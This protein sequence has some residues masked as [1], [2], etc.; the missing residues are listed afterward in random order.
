MKMQDTMEKIIELS[1]A[2]ECIVISE[3]SSNA[4]VRWANN[5]TTTNG[6]AEAR[7][8]YV[9][10]IKN[11]RVGVVGRTYFPD[12]QLEDLVR[13]SE[14]ACE[15]KPEAEDYAPLIEGISNDGWGESLDRIGIEVFSNFAPELAQVFKEAGSS[16]IKLF[17]FAD[18]STSAVYLATSSGMRLGHMQGEGKLELNAKS[19]DYSRSSWVGQA[20]ST[21]KDID[22][23][24]HYERLQQRLGWA[25]K[26]LDLDP[27]HYE[28]LLEPSAVS[29]MLLYSYW[30]SSARDTDEGRT[31]F[32]KPGGGNRKGEKLYPDNVTIYSDPSEPGFEV[33]PFQV[34]PTSSSHAS[35]FDNGLPCD[36]TEWV[37]KGVLENLVT[38][39]YWADKTEGRAVPFIDNL[40][41]PSSG[42]SLDD[43]ISSTKRA[44]L[45]TCLWYIREVDPQ[46]LLLTGLTRDGVFLVE[47][48][49][50][51]GAVNNFR[52]NMSPVAMLAQAQELGASEPTLA[53]EFGDYF[54]FAKVPPVRVANWNMSSVSQ[55]T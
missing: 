21:F 44:L 14:A 6:V 12:D 10:S 2:D 1:R 41:F 54:T 32:S 25:E 55:A 53:R 49:E 30:T 17:G 15:D 22:L 26:S 47:D 13:E 28:V 27:G 37:S 34:V 43:M 29:D 38:P 33:S 8:L 5:T 19:S 48:G 31:V 52:F 36:R 9:I 46:T 42:P 16:D 7:Q 45:V 11:K 40:I 50:V 23:S 4:N 51:K 20:T 35:V 39:R 18:H 3:E 24:H